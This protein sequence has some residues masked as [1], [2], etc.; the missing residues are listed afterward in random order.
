MYVVLCCPAVAAFMTTGAGVIADIFP[1]EVSS[2]AYRSISRRAIA[3][4]AKHRSTRS[5]TSSS[6]CSSNCSS[7]TATQLQEQGQEHDGSQQ[8]K[9]A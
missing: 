3:A 9:R 8:Q 7:S 2:A 1:P 4:A 5:T 6:N